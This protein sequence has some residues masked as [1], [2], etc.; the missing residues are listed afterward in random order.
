[1]PRSQVSGEL[2]YG[3]TSFIRELQRG[4]RLSGRIARASRVIVGRHQDTDAE[5]AEPS[6][7]PPDAEGGGPV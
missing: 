5:S 3:G 6:L 1:M 4:Y 7:P 2:R